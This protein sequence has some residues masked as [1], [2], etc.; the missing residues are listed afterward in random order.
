M[1]VL[2]R[3]HEFCEVLD[4]CKCL[5]S[6]CSGRIRNS[7]DTQ[8]AWSENTSLCILAFYL[9]KQLQISVSYCHFSLLPSQELTKGEAVDSQ[10][11]WSCCSTLFS[12]NWFQ[13][14]LSISDGSLDIVVLCLLSCLRTNFSCSF[15][16]LGLMFLCIY[17]S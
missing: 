15:V 12:T 3:R 9:L 16:L 2:K 11:G 5:N 4:K 13:I 8:D 7:S 10:A 6:S 1:Q 17:T 14:V